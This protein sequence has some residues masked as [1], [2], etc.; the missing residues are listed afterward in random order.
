MFVHLAL[1]AWGMGLVYGCAVGAEEA[2]DADC[3]VGSEGCE[4]TLGGGCDADLDCLSGFCVS[5]GG[6]G[7]NS[8]GGN[9]TGS[10]G[11]GTNA[12]SGTGGN[13]M[14]GS[15]ASSGG[16]PMTSATSTG[17]MMATTTS[18]TS[19][20]SGM[21]ALAE[22]TNVRGCT[23]GCG[24]CDSWPFSWDPVAGATHYRIRWSCSALPENTSMDI[25]GTTADF[26]NG[27][28]VDAGNLGCG[29]TIHTVFVMACDGT[30]CTDGTAVPMAELPLTCGG[31]CCL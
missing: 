14:A 24:A 27:P 25:V 15:T 31:G 26:A 22:P 12:A 28:E 13:P 29:F 23:S 16:A 30:C 9:M 20:G 5:F 17:A 4:C 3:A 8:A 11:S 1:A 6:G 19:T 10:N 7:G 2:G 18:T 21:C